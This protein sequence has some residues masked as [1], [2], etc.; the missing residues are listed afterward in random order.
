MIDINEEYDNNDEDDDDDNPFPPTSF[1][2]LTISTSSTPLPSVIPITPLS[3]LSLSKPPNNIYDDNLSTATRRIGRWNI[4][5]DDQHQ[6]IDY[7]LNLIRDEIIQRTQL[8]LLYMGNPAL[9]R[10]VLN[11]KRLLNADAIESL[12][13]LL[14]RLMIGIIIVVDSSDDNNDDNYHNKNDE[15]GELSMELAIVAIGAVA[16]LTCGSA[17]HR[18]RL[19]TFVLSSSMSS[20]SFS[21]LSSLSSNKDGKKKLLLPLLPPLSLEPYSEDDNNGNWND[22]GNDEGNENNLFEHEIE[23]LTRDVNSIHKD[24]TIPQSPIQKMK[25]KKVVTTSTAKVNIPINGITILVK[26][27]ERYDGIPRTILL[28]LLL[29]QSTTTTTTTTMEQQTVKRTTQEE[30]RLFSNLSRAIRNT[31]RGCRRTCLTLLRDINGIGVRLLTN[32]VLNGCSYSCSRLGSLP[33]SLLLQPPRQL[34][35]QLLPKPSDPDR[36]SCFRSAVALLNVAEVCHEYVKDVCHSRTTTSVDNEDD[37]N[38]NDLLIRIFIEAW[39]GVKKVV[40]QLH[41]EGAG[42]TDGGVGIINKN[43]KK[44]KY[45][46]GPVLHPGLKAILEGW[47]LSSKQ[48]ELSINDRY[49]KEGVER[50]ED[51]SELIDGI[52]QREMERKD[53]ARRREKE[54]KNIQAKKERGETSA[55]KYNKSEG[56]I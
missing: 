47:M 43:G 55:I 54:R 12:L 25:E 33:S 19:S 52:L 29:K 24:E 28:R 38:N 21:S 45:K 32:R 9:C 5:D 48:Q 39:G 15:I 41:G 46:S 3:S 51:L 10:S 40:Q 20:S 14:H 1:F 53:R 36:E 17:D 35:H 4:F 13:H 16:D 49:I 37:D 2:S 31:T 8:I 50:F 27:L 11:S 42:G 7:K 26:Y 34:P 18:D 23:K 56:C 44:K 30:L 22:G 6:S